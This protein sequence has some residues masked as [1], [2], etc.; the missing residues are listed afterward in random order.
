[1]KGRLQRGP[2]ALTAS[3]AR[4][5]LPTLLA[6]ASH[7]PEPFGAALLRSPPTAIGDRHLHKP[8]RPEAAGGELQVTQCH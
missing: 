2:A 6:A 7:Q 5:S 8:G 1:M 3:S 4:R